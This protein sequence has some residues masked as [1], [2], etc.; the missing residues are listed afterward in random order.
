[1]NPKD[2]GR[3]LGQA[4][5]HDRQLAKMVYA[6]MEFERL[7]MQVKAFWSKN[8]EGFYVVTAFGFPCSIYVLA[9]DR[10]FGAENEMVSARVQRLLT[11]HDVEVTVVP[12]AD[13][14]DIYRRGIP[15]LVKWRI[16][17]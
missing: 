9:H 6:R 3:K 5:E 13:L 10:W 15:G 7:D 17:K 12:P 14:N 16:L 11:P 1:M 2:L 4:I 8:H